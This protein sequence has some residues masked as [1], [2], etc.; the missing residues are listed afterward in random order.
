MRQQADDDLCVIELTSGQK[1]AGEDA[2]RRVLMEL[3][4]VWKLLAPLVTLP[5]TRWL[6]GWM[7]RYRAWLSH[8]RSTTPECERPGVVCV[9][10]FL[11]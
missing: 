3:G 11:L 5:P 7:V 8:F 4:G 1:W 2:V 10:E 6:Y 9:Q